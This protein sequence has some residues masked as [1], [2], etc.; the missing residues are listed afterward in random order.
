[1]S[2]HTSAPIDRVLLDHIARTTYCTYMRSIV[3]YRIAL[4]VGRSVR[5]VS[6]AK[7][8]EPTEMPFGLRTR[9]GPGNHVLDRGPDPPWDGAILRGRGGPL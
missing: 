9:V 1:M 4:S 7:T 3:T 6:P 2:H 5:L 8:T